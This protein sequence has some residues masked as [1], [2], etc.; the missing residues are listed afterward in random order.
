MTDSPTI[1]VFD[2]LCP[3]CS[4]HARFI[5]KHDRRRRFRLAAMQSEAGAALYRRFGLDPA[6]PDSL[7]LVEGGRMRHGSDAV[8]A[9]WSGLG[10]PWRLAAAARLIPAF[11]RDPVYSWVARNRYRLFGRRETCWAPPAQW[12]DRLL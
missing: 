7:I 11:L 1:I 4:A 12:H 3:L 10:W 8:L 5:L 2:G 9:I 6:D